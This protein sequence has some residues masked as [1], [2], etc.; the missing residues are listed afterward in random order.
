MYFRE[1]DQLV[2][3][4]TQLKIQRGLLQISRLA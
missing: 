3:I 4:D 2:W 1:H